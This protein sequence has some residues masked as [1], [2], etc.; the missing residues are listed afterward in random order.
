MPQRDSNSRHLGPKPSA[1]PLS[2]EGIPG[3]IDRPL[4][5]V[6]T[7][8][9]DLTNSMSPDRVLGQTRTGDLP[10]RRRLL[11]PLSYEDIRVN[12]GT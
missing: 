8:R 1:L 5:A 6:R 7:A 3:L 12:D 11:Y 10:L 9:I 4:T 2:Y